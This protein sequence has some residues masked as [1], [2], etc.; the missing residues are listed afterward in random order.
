MLAMAD[1][2]GWGDPDPEIEGSGFKKKFFRPFGP[3]FG[4]NLRG[5]GG[6]GDEGS[7]IRQDR[8]G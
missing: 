5:G 7:G 4:L 2:G 3:Q 6:G 8:L 1:P